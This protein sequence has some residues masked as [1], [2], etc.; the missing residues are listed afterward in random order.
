MGTSLPFLPFIF[1]NNTNR[2]YLAIAFIV[3]LIQLMVFKHFYPYPDFI[4]DSYSY[5]D[6]NLYHMNVNLWPVGYSRFL[7][8]I[9]LFTSSHIGL[10][11]IQYF[12]LVVTLL[13]FFFTIRYLYL[14][15]IRYTIALFI[16]L[17]LNPIF[18][19]LANCI[20]SDAIFCAISLV[21]FT[22]YLWMFHRPRTGNIIFQA[23]LIAIAF[24][25]RYTAIYYPL[26]TVIAIMLSDYKWSLKLV[27]VILPWVL[28]IPFIIYTQ[29][30]TKKLTGTAEFSVFGGWQLANNALYM[31]GHINVDST[32]LPPRTRTL[33]SVTKAFWQAKALTE[34]DLAAVP[35]TFFIKVPQAILKPYMYS[36]GRANL[37]GAPGWFQAWGSVS[38]V[39]NAYGKWL[40]THYPLAFSRYYLWP[41]VKNYFNPYLE[42]FGSYNIG[43]LDVWKPAV[44]WF[45][46]KSN[47]VSLIPHI[48]F[49]G[50]IF[51]PYPLFFMGLNIYFAI[52]AFFFLA[53]RKI[54]E[55]HVTFRIA[56]LLT[57]AFLVINF[58][59]SVFATPVVLRYQV[60]PM[61][62]LLTFSLLLTEKQFSST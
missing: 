27:A 43:K 54:K 16:F 39:Y 51:R 9:H 48:N 30:E 2:L 18:L 26:L 50:R 25:I 58:G 46:L 22:Q 8:F 37:T 14:L 57:I 1:K 44:T 56:I 45:N 5:I 35:G 55:K 10:V 6:T 34:A 29:Q 23:V 52:C 40:I 20:L 11:Y 31:Y 24:S 15:S 32:E 7:A 49:Q 19:V 59:F 38:P 33:D 62:I 60:L 61:I 42:K 13:Y 41:N 36:H 53:D 12:I 28:I 4:S 17:F 21:L 47:K 3:G